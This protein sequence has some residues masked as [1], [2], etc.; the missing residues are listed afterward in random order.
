[1]KLATAKFGH[2]LNPDLLKLHWERSKGD[3]TKEKTAKRQKLMTG[4]HNTETAMLKSNLIFFPNLSIYHDVLFPGLCLSGLL[5]VNMFIPKSTF[6]SPPYCQHVTSGE[7]DQIL[8][9][10]LNPAPSGKQDTI[11]C[12][13][14]GRRSVRWRC[15]G[16]PLP[17]P[18]QPH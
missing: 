18:T 13:W 7:A 16:R 6:F 5:A 4:D 10:G 12:H 15:Q 17:F 9:L 8:P 11:C 1:M 2:F 14:A 3:S